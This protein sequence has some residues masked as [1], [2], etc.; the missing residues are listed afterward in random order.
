MK[1]LH[2]LKE[3]DLRPQ[4]NYAQVKNGRV[5]LTDQC[6]LIVMTVADVFGS[7][8]LI[9]DEEELYIPFKAWGILKFPTAKWITREG[10]RFTNSHGLTIDL[11]SAAE[12]ADK[13]GRYPDWENILPD[14]KK[15][16]VP[17]DNIGFNG[18]KLKQICDITGVPEWSFEFYGPDKCIM[19]S[20]CKNDSDMY[21][22]LMPVML[23]GKIKKW[24]QPVEEIE[25]FLN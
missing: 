8:E 4:F 23:S 5:V 12:Y 6:I 16:L 14:H 3:N 9:A 21:A 7:N 24:H 25:D 11:L 1:K 22:L 18:E 2:L 17:V 15:P 10:N 13:V 20:P 19:L